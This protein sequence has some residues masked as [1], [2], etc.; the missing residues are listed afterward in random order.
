MMLIVDGTGPADDYT[1]YQ[2]MRGSF[3]AQLHRKLTA[4]GARYYRGPS[5]SGF[6]GPQLDQIETTMK[7]MMLQAK[8]PLFMAGYSRGGAAVIHLANKMKKEGLKIKAMF[9]FDAVARD[10]SLDAE[11]IPNSVDNVYFA[12]RD[13]TITGGTY[14]DIDLFRT[15]NKPIVDYD[16][17]KESR[18]WMSNC[19]LVRETGKGMGEHEQKTFTGGS[20]AALGGVP[21]MS[22]PAEKAAVTEV[23]NWMTDRLARHK[24][25][26][27][28][29]DEWNVSLRKRKP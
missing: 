11:V 25:S 16:Y 9:L 22:G 10:T 21:W 26:V 13:T 15:D 19:G 28:L 24:I 20:H 3:C 4:Y 29:R 7:A 14:V 23:A 1:Y 17:E 18:T 5:T 8:G 6:S 2:N 27:V 12:Q